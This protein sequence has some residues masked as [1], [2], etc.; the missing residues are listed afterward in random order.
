MSLT[1]AD[2]GPPLSDD[3]L[4]AF[5]R[6]I[7]RLL[8]ADYRDFLLRYNGG[9]PPWHVIRS[10]DI[11]D[12]GVQLFYGIRKDEPFDIDVAHERTRGRWPDRFLAIAIDSFGNAFCLSLAETDAGTIYFWDHE[13]APVEPGSEHNLF[14]LANS[15]A[16]FWYLMEPIDRDEYLREWKRSHPQE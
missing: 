11:G 9:I 13:A 15:F 3:A 1:L 8:P 5:E 2:C 4:T 6:R 16:E 14:P 10:S 7:R 12:L